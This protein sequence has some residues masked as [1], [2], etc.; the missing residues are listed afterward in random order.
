LEETIAEFLYMHLD[1]SDGLMWL[2]ISV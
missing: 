1:K 2:K